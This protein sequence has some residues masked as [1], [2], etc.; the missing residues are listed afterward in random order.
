[1]TEIQT[2]PVELG[3]VVICM[4]LAG[5]PVGFV[6]VCHPDGIALLCISAYIPIIHEV[7]RDTDINGHFACSFDYQPFSLAGNVAVGA[8]HLSVANKIHLA[9]E[10]LGACA[11]SFQPQKIVRCYADANPGHR[12]LIEKLAVKAFRSRG[13]DVIYNQ[14]VHK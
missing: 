14:I 5:L 11:H 8:D 9:R 1:M 4:F 7:G 3:L 6:A 12:T 10:E 13:R 2:H